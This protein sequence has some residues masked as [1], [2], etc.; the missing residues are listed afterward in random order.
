MERGISLKLDTH[1]IRFRFWLSFFLLAVGIIVFI[2]VLQ[3]GLIRPYY[4]N[5]KVQTVR[6][7]ADTVQSDLLDQKATE[8][9]VSAALKEVVDNNACILIFNDSGRQ[10]YD[11]DSLG[12]SCVLSGNVPDEVTQLFDTARMNELLGTNREYSINVTNP[13]TSQEMIVF[14]RRIQAELGNYY[15]Y[16]NTPLEPVDS[17]VTFFTRQYVIYTLIAMIVAS[18]VGFY[19]SRTVTDPIV[20]M[21]KEAGKLA[22]ADYSADF[23]GGSFTETKELAATLN[24]ANEKL[25]SIDALRRDLIANVSHDIRTPIT[26]I[27]AYA[28][29]IRDIS[30]DD[31]VKRD[32]HLDVILK[33][34]DY[35][36]SLV[37]DMSELSKMQTGTYIPRKENM[38]LSEKIYEVVDMNQPLI[39]DAGVEVEIDVPEYLTVYADELK[40]GQIITNYLTN[41]IKHTPK[42]GKI[43]IRAWT[44]ED[45]ETVRMEVID[46]GEG[47]KA[48]DL[49]NI[50][51]RYQK[52]SHS[53]S[54]SQTSTGLGLAIV[55]AIA[56]SHGAGYGVESEE[57]KG[58]TFWLE[59]KETHEG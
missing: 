30:G 54:R 47:I 53:F 45:E 34:A 23:D 20:R 35:M 33:E 57:G 43:T 5:S 41:A 29:M 36:S 28:E 46:E 37:T 31:P 49:P 15:I 52:S 19:I 21:K 17:I 3:T 55:R 51:D 12:T 24:H 2:G 26:D 7:L 56:E 58:S 42:G 16:V 25:S 39:D 13:S 1:G 14:A 22:R 48:E 18:V 50:W 8:K 44:K 9:G 40:I 11:A 38:D 10:I 27:K 6:T 4:R 59:L 32:K